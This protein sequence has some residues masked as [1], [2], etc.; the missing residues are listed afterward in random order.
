MTGQAVRYRLGYE[1]MD[2]RLLAEERIEATVPP[3]AEIGEGERSG[4]WFELRDDQ[5]CV[6]YRRVLAT[7][8]SA[9]HEVYDQESGTPSRVAGAP[10]SGTLWLLVPSFPDARQLVVHGSPPEIE[11]RAE[12]ARELVRFDIG[13]GR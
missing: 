1:G 12:A 7:P 3:S 9:E 4:F 2:V 13:A 10:A 11:R 8:F 6:L 5:E